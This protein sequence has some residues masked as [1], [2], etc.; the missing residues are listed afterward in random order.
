MM[1][2][3]GVHTSIAGGLHMA[4]ERARALGC[5]TA[6]IFSHNPRGWRTREIPAEEAARFRRLAQRYSVWPI[7]VHASYLINISSPSEELRGKSA[8]LL[9]EEIRR[10]EQ[11]GADYVVLHTGAPHD[12]DGARRAASSIFEA[13]GRSGGRA[14][15]LLENTASP[16]TGL[17][18][19]LA[20]A[21]GA[22]S[23]VCLDSCHAFAAGYDV[24][25]DGGID[26]LLAALAGHRIELLHLNDS[27]GGLGSGLDRHEHIGEGRIGARGLRKFAGHEA[28]AEIPLILET[29]KKSDTDDVENLG[30]VRKMLSISVPKFKTIVS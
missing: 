2:R 24:R 28:L 19:I 26:S 29:P 20:E 5:S 1:R 13:V 23:G 6:Q 10:A 8:A 30:K 14:G 18:G 21:E 27:R 15:L 4:L 16:L 3:L 12:E 11:I 22:V 25:T 9:K 7:Y 17:L